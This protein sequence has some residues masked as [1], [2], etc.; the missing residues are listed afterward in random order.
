[1]NKRDHLMFDTP[2]IVE[3]P[4]LH[5]DTLSVWFRLVSNLSNTASE[6]AYWSY[7]PTRYLIPRQIHIKGFV[8]ISHE[9]ATFYN[10]LLAVQYT[11]YPLL[12]HQ[13]FELIAF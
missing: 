1:M 13:Q 12:P 3:S 4:W 2:G 9:C 6:S 8:A 10:E 5:I 7:Y 11:K